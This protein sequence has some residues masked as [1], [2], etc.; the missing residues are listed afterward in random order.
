MRDRLG[1]Q[2]H[3][4]VHAVL[5]DVRNVRHQRRDELPHV[6]H[7]GLHAAPLLKPVLRELPLDYVQRR[8]HLQRLRVTLQHMH[9]LLC[10]LVLS[11]QRREHAHLPL[12][13]FV[14]FCVPLRHHVRFVHVHHV[15][16]AL[17]R[18]PDVRLHVRQV[19]R[20]QEALLQH[21]R[22]LV[23]HRHLPD[24]R[25]VQQRDDRRVQ[26]VLLLLLHVRHV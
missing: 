10:V 14:H 21:L 1:Q 26:R 2:G 9:I 22:G 25:N 24:F 11:Q 20:R 17:P 16:L 23:P 15:L 5:L 18:V 12:G 8:L 4:H 7:F 19:H 3:V 6:R 13:Y